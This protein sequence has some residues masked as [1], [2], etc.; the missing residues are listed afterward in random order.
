MIINAHCL[1]KFDCIERF[2]VDANLVWQTQKMCTLV[3]YCR[4]LFVFCQA[5]SLYVYLCDLQCVK[6]KS[7]FKFI[8]SSLVKSVA[9]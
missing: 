1:F 9:Q 4:D 6:T 8:S 2:S 5:Y 7:D 3:R